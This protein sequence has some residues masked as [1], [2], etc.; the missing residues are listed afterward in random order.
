MSTIEEKDRPAWVGK[1][2]DE[3]MDDL[4]KNFT[5]MV[6][7]E[8]RRVMRNKLVTMFVPN[9]SLGCFEVTVQDHIGRFW[10]RKVRVRDVVLRTRND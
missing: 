2:L 3:A 7:G 9:N 8:H 4:T 5:S 6:H 10:V 1:V